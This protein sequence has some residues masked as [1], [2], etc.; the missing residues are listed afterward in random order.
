MINLYFPE[1]EIQEFLSSLQ[2]IQIQDSQSQISEED[3]E[4][5][6]F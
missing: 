2:E 1:E 5:L 4:D 3:F 6:K